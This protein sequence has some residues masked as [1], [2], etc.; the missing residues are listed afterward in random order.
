ML[1]SVADGDLTVA[2]AGRDEIGLMSDAVNRPTASIRQT[3]SALADSART[4]A[5]SSH[6]PSTSAEAIAGNA[7]DTS[8]QTGLLAE[9]AEDVSRSVQTVA[10]GTEE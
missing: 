4:L 3:V 10:A 6:R 7:G 1:D 9:A 2:A 8:T 5:D